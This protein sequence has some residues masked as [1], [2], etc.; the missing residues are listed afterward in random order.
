M[1]SRLPTG[2]FFSIPIVHGSP[3]VRFNGTNT[4]TYT[5]GEPFMFSGGDKVSLTR[6]SVYYSWFNISQALGNNIL[7]YYFPGP[8][9]ELL[10]Y[11]NQMPDGI[12]T[13]TDISNM[14]TQ[15]QKDNGHYLID[16]SGVQKYFLS[17]SLNRIQYSLTLVVNPVPTSLAVGWT[18]PNKITLSGI[19]PQLVVTQDISDLLGFVPGVYPSTK[20]T[21]QYI[22]NSTT[23]PQITKSSTVNISTNLIYS[24]SLTESSYYIGNFSTNGAAAGS[25][26][27]CQETVDRLYPAA[28]GANI[29]EVRVSLLDQLGNPIIV[30]DPTGFSATFAIQT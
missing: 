23:A 24:R 9:G 20:T 30:Y 3:N 29:T 25:L 18:N 17:L 4:W 15:M 27:T 11:Q 26:I 10:L 21:N 28:A 12:Y 6:L 14:L 13:F 19:C 2:T 8:L 16:D 1:T 7:G 22:A 5:L